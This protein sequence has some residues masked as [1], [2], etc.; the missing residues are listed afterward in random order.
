MNPPERP[1][2]PD[3]DALASRLPRYEPRSEQVAAVRDALL[4]EAAAV[5]PPRRWGRKWTWLAA[6]GLVAA[7]AMLALWLGRGQAPLTT[8]PLTTAP[9]ATAPL[10]TAPLATAPL[11]TAPLATANRGVLRMR[12][13]TATFDVETPL[14]IVAGDS[15]IVADPG[16]KLEAEIRGDRLRRVTVSAGWVVIAP[17]ASQQGVPVLVTSQQS[18]VLEAEPAPPSAP[19]T[20][21]AQKRTAVPPRP[22]VTAAPSLRPPVTAAPSLRPPVTAA[23]SLRPPITAAPAIEGPTAKIQ[24]ER[25][26]RVT[27]E[28]PATDRAA[29]PRR[30]P[31]QPAP[32]SPSGSSPKPLAPTPSKPPPSPH[33][34]APFEEQ[35]AKGLR[36]LTSGKVAESI[37]PLQLVCGA[38][39][40]S[41]TEEACFWVA[42]AKLRAGDR[43][44]ASMSFARFL[45]VWPRS[46][47]AGEASVSL[48]WLLME[49]GD[50][51]SARARFKAAAADPSPSVRSSA[52]RGL[53][54]AA[55]R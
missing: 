10:T 16:A 37:A 54:A 2:L 13:G 33:R 7:A 3:V 36:A 24:L 43:A 40:S 50:R 21:P 23:P 12:E 52:T 5:A 30:L 18:W 17:H 55:D 9:L 41:L 15:E 49:N 35:F 1:P 44:G 11:A 28:P 51:S 4:A 34:A 22:P 42:V 32:S 8:A 20:A 47:H 25:A 27:L 19:A 45:A 29:E 48:G 39:S 6:P 38:A 53:A 26:P 14:R 31:P 46:S